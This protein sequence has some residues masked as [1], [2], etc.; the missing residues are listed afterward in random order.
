MNGDLPPDPPGGRDRSSDG[1]WCR[2]VH[3]AADLERSGAMNARTRE[4]LTSS[5]TASD[6]RAPPEAGPD[7]A[8][9][10]GTAQVTRRRRLVVA[11]R[12]QARATVTSFERE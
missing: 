9:A 5:T 11:F 3:S 7:V 2:I 6:E 10:R 1:S 4:A 8:S 12:M